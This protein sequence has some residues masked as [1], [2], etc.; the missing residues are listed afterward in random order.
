MLS[1][2]HHW[3]FLCDMLNECSFAI[4]S[5]DPPTCQVPLINKCSC[6]MLIMCRASLSFLVRDVCLQSLSVLTAA[7]KCLS[8][9]MCFSCDVCCLNVPV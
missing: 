9:C 7:L 8:V 4:N 3:P 2:D 5:D 1:G 6:D